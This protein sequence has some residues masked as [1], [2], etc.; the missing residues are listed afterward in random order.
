MDKIV[1]PFFGHTRAE[2]DAG[3]IFTSLSF[4][5]LRKILG[6]AIDLDADEK[7]AGLIIAEDGI[8]IRIEKY[9]IV[10]KP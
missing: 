6:A 5:S 9:R 4:D 2:V 7:I 1:V 10:E 8:K 3:G